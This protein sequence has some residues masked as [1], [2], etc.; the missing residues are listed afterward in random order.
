RPVYDITSPVFDAVTIQ[1]HPD[2]YRGGTFR[3]VTHDNSAEHMYIQRAALNGRRQD[4][5]WFHHDRLAAGGTLELWMGP[6]PNKDWGVAELPPSR[7]SEAPAVLYA[8]RDTVRVDSGETGSLTLAARNLT[9]RP[10]AAAWH[11]DAP[12]GIEVR[13][14]RGR[15]TAPGDDTAEQDLTLRVAAGTP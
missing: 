12:A 3:I 4:N 5:A 14:A 7:S 10:V 11:A 8:D 1:L 6:E 15:L 2:Y 13:P 9:S